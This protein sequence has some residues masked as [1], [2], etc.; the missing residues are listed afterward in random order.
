VTTTRVKKK[1]HRRQRRKKIAF[2]RQ[3][4]EDT[5]DESRR[6]RLIAKLYRVSRGAPA[7]TA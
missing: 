3:R 7:E 2:L 4:I 1:Q 6:Q 5:H